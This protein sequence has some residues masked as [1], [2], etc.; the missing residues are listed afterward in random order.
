M[1][2]E[3]ARNPSTPEADRKNRWYARE[4]GRGTWEVYRNTYLGA[5][6]VGI[7]YTG[8][9]AEIIC[10]ALNMY[11]GRQERATFARPVT[12]RLKY[13]DEADEG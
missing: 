5:E 12:L 10:E 2:M 7:A 8:K 9:G 3:I 1:V 4:T 6:V 13:K 11:E